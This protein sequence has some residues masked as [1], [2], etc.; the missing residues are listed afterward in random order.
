MPYIAGDL[1]RVS[2]SFETG[3]IATDPTTVVLR[4]KNPAGTPTTWTFGVDSQVVKNSVGNYRADINANV[5]GT[6]YFRWEGTGAAQGVA[7]DSFV[8]TATNI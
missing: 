7:Q 8:V 5:G 1:V 3:G 2:V 4:Y 6:W